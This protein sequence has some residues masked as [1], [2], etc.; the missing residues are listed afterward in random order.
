MNE[1]KRDGDNVSVIPEGNLIASVANV[2]RT[3]LSEVLDDKPVNLT[4]DL[5]E[6]EMVDSV[7]I[8]VI[9]AT[10][11]SVAKNGGTLR[12]INVKEDIYDLLCTMRLNN[13]FEILK[14]L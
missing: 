3:D 6:S 12:V 9:I 7:G 1:I 10:H 2:L 4:I 14:S 13:H 11:N 8:G 5:N